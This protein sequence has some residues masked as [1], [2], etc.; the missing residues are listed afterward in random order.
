MTL[1]GPRP[2]RPRWTGTTAL[3]PHDPNHCPTC[4]T[5]LDHTHTT[6]QPLLRHGGYGAAT[7]TTTRTCPRCGYHGGTTTGEHRPS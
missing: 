4:H 1:F 5:P 7:T 2:R 3:V 6:Q